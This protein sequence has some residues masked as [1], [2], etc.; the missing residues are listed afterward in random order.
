MVDPVSIILGMVE[1]LYQIGRFCRFLSVGRL[2]IHLISAGNSFHKQIL[3]IENALCF[4]L[5]CFDLGF[6]SC[7]CVSAH[8]GFVCLRGMQLSWWFRD[9][10]GVSSVAGT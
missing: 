10:D 1:K 9:G 6:V 5:V 8:L 3:L 2:W 4:I 7:I